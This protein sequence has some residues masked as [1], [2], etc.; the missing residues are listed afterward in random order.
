MALSRN[1]DESP[2]HYPATAW[3]FTQLMASLPLG[4]SSSDSTVVLTVALVL[5]LVG[6]FACWLPARCAAALDPVNAIR[7]E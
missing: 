4:V 5:A 6:L 1:L 7:Y 2:S 3:P